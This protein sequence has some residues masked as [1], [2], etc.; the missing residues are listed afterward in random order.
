MS[1]N[2]ILSENRKKK[3]FYLKKSETGGVGFQTCIFKSEKLLTEGTTYG[4]GK[5]LDIF[6]ANMEDCLLNKNDETCC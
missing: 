6:L 3:V 1:S 5:L 2:Y 4:T